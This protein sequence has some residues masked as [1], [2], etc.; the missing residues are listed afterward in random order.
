MSSYQ[1]KKEAVKERIQILVN[2]P[3]QMVRRDRAKGA[4]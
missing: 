3:P 2:I 4:R 1:G